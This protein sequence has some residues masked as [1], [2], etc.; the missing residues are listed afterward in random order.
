MRTFHKGVRRNSKRLAF[1]VLS[2]LLLSPSAAL[3]HDVTPGDAGYIQEIWG[4]HIIPF[5]YLGA[6]HMV[7]G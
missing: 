5:M 3:A 4:V 6:K 1:F 2:M 7:T